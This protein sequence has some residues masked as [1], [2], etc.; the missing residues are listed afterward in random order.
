MSK[1]TKQA[2]AHTPLGGNWNE[3]HYVQ[4]KIGQLFP[5]ELRKILIGWAVAY[6]LHI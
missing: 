6:N 4:P 2:D 3:I 5:S 1:V